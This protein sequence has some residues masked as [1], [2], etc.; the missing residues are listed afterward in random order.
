[1]KAK[2]EDIT[3]SLK[4]GSFYPCPSVAK[5]SSLKNPVFQKVG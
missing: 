4:R 3:P 2:E 5:K 1:M